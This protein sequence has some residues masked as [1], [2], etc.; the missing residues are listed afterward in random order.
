MYIHLLVNTSQKKFTLRALL[1]PVAQESLI[2]EATVQFLR[3]PKPKYHFQVSGI[4]NKNQLSNIIVTFQ[5]IL[6]D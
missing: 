5:L 3:L 6:R 1:D 4:G 2:T